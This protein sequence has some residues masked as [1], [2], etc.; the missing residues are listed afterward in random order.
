MRET[1]PYGS[2]RG[3]SSNGRPYRDRTARFWPSLPE[4]KIRSG[5]FSRSFFKEEH[6]AIVWGIKTAAGF[7]S[8]V[9]DNHP[10][11]GRKFVKLL[12]C[13]ALVVLK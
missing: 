10:T 7:R 9:C 12:A 11:N 8:D 6:A 3:A 5:Q 1:C 4:F 13:N 2:M